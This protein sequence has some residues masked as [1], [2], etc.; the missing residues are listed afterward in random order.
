MDKLKEDDARFV[1]RSMQ[2]INFEREMYKN[3]DQDLKQLWKDM[4]QKYLYRGLDTELNNE[5]ATIPHYLTHPGYYQNYFRASL[6]KAQIYN[7]MKNELGDISQNTKTSEF[8]NNKLFRYGDSILE[9]DL[10]RNMTGKDL[11]EE[12][13]CNRITK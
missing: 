8:L 4:K 7:A 2:I 11:S 3:P 5:W 10:I 1:T 9:E 6:L 12:D 13:F